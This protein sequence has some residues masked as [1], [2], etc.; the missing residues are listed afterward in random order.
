MTAN[1]AETSPRVTSASSD[2]GVLGTAIVG[3]VRVHLM[4]NVP[5]TTAQ[6]TSVANATRRSRADSDAWEPLACVNFRLLA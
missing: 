4:A 1:F 2:W 6:V 5:T 3:G